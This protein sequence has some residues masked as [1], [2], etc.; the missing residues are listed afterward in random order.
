MNLSSYIWNTI[1]YSMQRMFPS[2]FSDFNFLH[3]AHPY[4]SLLACG[5]HSLYTF[6]YLIWFRSELSRSE[7]LPFPTLH[8]LCPRSM[9]QGYGARGPPDVE[10]QCPSCLTICLAGWG[11]CSNIWRKSSCHC[12]QITNAIFCILIPIGRFV[13]SSVLVPLAFA[14]CPVHHWHV[15]PSMLS[16]RERNVWTED[17]SSPLV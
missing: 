12:N 16:L 2:E 17:V 13:T 9:Q 11:W 6:W 3:V 4:C 15:A 10:W 1:P 5:A 8:F 14:S 7:G